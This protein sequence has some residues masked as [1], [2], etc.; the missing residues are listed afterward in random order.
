MNLILE[1]HLDNVKMNYARKCLGERSLISRHIHRDDCTTWTTKLGYAGF[2]AV[3]SSPT[4]FVG[5]R[6]SD[7]FF[8]VSGGLSVCLC[9]VFLSRL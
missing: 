5:S 7:H 6:P 3:N 2:Y 1:L 8:V 4:V 9:R